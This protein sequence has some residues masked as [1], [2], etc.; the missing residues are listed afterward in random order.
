MKRGFFIF[1]LLGVCC[2]TNLKSQ[3]FKIEYE[4]GIGYYSMNDLKEL[5]ESIAKGLPFETKL[6]S[7][8]P[9]YWFY[10]PGIGLK[11]NNLELTMVL[12]YFSTGSRIAA[13]DYSANYKFDTK[14]RSFSPG[15]KIKYHFKQQNKLFFSTYGIL[16]MDFTSLELKDLLEITESTM[17]NSNMK[18]NTNC[19]SIEPG[20]NVN[21]SIKFISVSL[22]FGYSLHL[23]KN[24][25]HLKDE[26]ERIL[27][28]PT[29]S[30]KIYPE[31]QGLRIGISLNF[32]L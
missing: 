20:V 23:K 18:F 28:N 9:N 4:Q 30:N 25:F 26:K 24:A 11:F 16:G 21:Y 5:N 32:D 6:V 12:S 29:S 31:W 8:F 3:S 17:V 1:I 10:R 13:K 14:V 19:F 7:D 22:N 27:Q 2:I 15:I